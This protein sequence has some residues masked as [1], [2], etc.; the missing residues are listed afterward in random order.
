MKVLLRPYHNDD[1]PA[2]AE[3]VNA[4]LDTLHPWLLWP[5]KGFTVEEACRWF[6]ATCTLRETGEAN[7][8]GLF[9]GD[10][11]RLLGGAGLRYSDQQKN[12]CSIGYWVR[13]SEQRKG[14]ASQA[15]HHLLE[16][17]WQS[18]ERETVEILAVAEN[19]ASRRVAEKCGGEF[20]GIR[21]GLIVLASGPVDTA[22]YHFHRTGNI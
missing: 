6:A 5:H 2:F 8:L 14:V 15:V 1:A 12:L 4:S 7:E 18:Q 19:I 10:D 9:A 21:H 13:S 3:A 22:I 20:V 17:A 11:G 16:L